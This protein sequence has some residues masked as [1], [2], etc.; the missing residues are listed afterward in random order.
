MYDFYLDGVRLPVAPSELTLKITNQNKTVSLINDGEINILKK[1][2]LT[3]ITFIALLPN[4]NYYFA[5]SNEATEYLDKI[6]KLKTSQKPFQFIVSRVLPDGTV[7]FDTNIKVSMEE[8]TIDETSDNGF[9]VSVDIKLKQYRD[10]GTKTIEVQDDGTAIQT[11]KRNE[12]G[13]TSA[14]S[15]KVVAGD[16]LW[17]IAK[18]ELGDG[19]R[20]KEIYELNKNVIDADNSGTGNLKYTIYPNQVLTLP[21]GAT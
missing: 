3:D 11:K 6:E 8:Y 5:E 15:H 18:T 17:A 4:T 7:L 10:Y 9:D 16:S 2:G 19:S 13:K 14:T 1:A 12:D 20:Y 21:Q